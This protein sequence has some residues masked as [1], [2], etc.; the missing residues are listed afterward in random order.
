MRS[1][2]RSLALAV[3]LTLLSSC[4][5][6]SRLEVQDWDCPPAPL[7]CARPVVVVGFPLP[8]ISDFHGISV[9]GSADVLGALMGEDLFHR[10]PF[11]ANVVLYFCLVLA[12]GW[13]AG[14]RR[15]RIGTSDL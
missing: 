14:S 3:V 13:T 2:L 6:R 8:Y 15:R 7:S 1:I 4:V 5:T 11:V 9:V 12:V 10:G